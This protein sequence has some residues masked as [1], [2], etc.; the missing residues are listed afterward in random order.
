MKTESKSKYKNIIT[1]IDGYKFPSKAEANRYLALK[2][3]EKSGQIKGLEI[4]PR[5]PLEVNGQ[6]ICIYEADFRYFDVERGTTR[7]EDVKGMR[8]AAF[9]LKKKLLKAC[10]NVDV[11]EIS[12][13]KPYW[14]VPF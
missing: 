7:V 12:R 6:R 9:V 8:T 3:L 14:Q 13:K 4:H 10:H 11:E 5:Y 2:L 1:V